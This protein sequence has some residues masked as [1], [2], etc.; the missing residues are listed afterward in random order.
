M[1]DAA[2]CPSHPSSPLPL[3]E[4]PHAGV[5]QVHAEL[6]AGG[7][8]SGSLPPSVVEVQTA[9]A[10]EAAAAAPSMLLLSS[11]HGDVSLVVRPPA[12]NTQAGGG[13]ASPTLA[14]PAFP[15]RPVPPLQGVRPV[16]LAAAFVLPPA[17]EGEGAGAAGAAAAAAAGAAAFDMCV[18]FWAARPHGE[19]RPSRCEVYAARLAA[20]L[21]PAP[22]LAVLSVQLLRVGGVPAKRGAGKSSIGPGSVHS[23]AA[24]LISSPLRPPRTL[25]PAPLIPPHPFRCLTC[26]RTVCWSTLPLA[27]CC[28]RCSPRR[29]AWRRRRRR[30][31]QRR[32]RRRQAQ[33]AGRRWTPTTME[34]S[35]PACWRRR[36]RAWRPTLQRSLWVSLALGGGGGGAGAGWHQ[37]WGSCLAAG[38]HRACSV[39]DPTAFRHLRCRPAAPP[40]VCR[41]VQRDGG[42][43]HRRHGLRAHLHPVHV[44]AGSASARGGG[45]AGGRAGAAALPGAHAVVPA[46][47]AAD[48]S[49]GTALGEDARAPHARHTPARR[50]RRRGAAA[51]RAARRQAA[52][53]PD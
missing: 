50:Q 8:T 42:R 31:G 6:P 48:M 15:L 19:R 35:A 36:R 12:D 27:A 14:P 9:A 30:S 11:G 21:G 33:R 18:L 29:P 46:A 28:W 16:H 2:C 38:H 32:W 7:P 53:G 26:R 25:S 4:P 49:P 52:A 23:R 37:G 24:G 22:S 5:P 41:P 47:Q 51:A 39:A 34:T 17:A 44:C 10:P 20:Q 40:A 3:L 13:A 43:R 45:T 1:I